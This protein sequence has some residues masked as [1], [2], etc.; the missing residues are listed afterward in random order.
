MKFKKRSTSKSRQRRGIAAVE[1]AMIAPAFLVVVFC[2]IE[3]ARMS[4]MR[5]LALNASYESARYTMVEGATEEDARLMAED[6]LSRL[7]TKDAEIVINEGNGVAFNSPTI[8]TEITI[9]LD[10]NSL[11]FPKSMFEG[12]VIYASTTLRTERYRGY[13]NADDN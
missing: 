5:N 9:P 3:F 7:G 8:R 12:K 13:Y 4:M 10:S 6:I 11:V 1:F 2:S